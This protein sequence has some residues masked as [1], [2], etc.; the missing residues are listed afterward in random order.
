METVKSSDILKSVSASTQNANDVER[1]RILN[2]TPQQCDPVI[3]WYHL[4]KDAI[5]NVDKERKQAADIRN[6]NEQLK[7]YKASEN[8]RMERER[9]SRTM[10]SVRELL[11]RVQKGDFSMNI[12]F[13]FYPNTERKE[14]G[15]YEEED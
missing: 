7:R 12:Q 11:Q 13:S 8:D 5:D 6:E 4:A 1:N 9:Q 3:Y 15:Y 2:I 10:P 14:G